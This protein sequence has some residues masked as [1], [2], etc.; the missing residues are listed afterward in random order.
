MIEITRDGEAICERAK[1]LL[2]SRLVEIT[3][4]LDPEVQREIGEIAAALADA[5][6]RSK[7]ERASAEGNT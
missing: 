4:H 6:D 2:F 1:A 7:E 5:M 3:K